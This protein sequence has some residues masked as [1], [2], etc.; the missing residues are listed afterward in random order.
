M[1]FDYIKAK[2]QGGETS[3]SIHSFKEEY[4]KEYQQLIEMVKP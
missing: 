3:I 1:F 4:Q 2:H